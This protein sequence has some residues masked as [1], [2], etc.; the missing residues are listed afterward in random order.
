MTCEETAGRKLWPDQL[1][2]AFAMIKVTAI[3]HWVMSK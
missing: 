3:A 2:R 1:G